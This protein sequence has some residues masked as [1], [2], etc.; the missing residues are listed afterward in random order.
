MS[1]RLS[2]LCLA[3]LAASGGV[4]HA[5]T[6]LLIHL[7]RP[8]QQIV[9]MGADMERSAAALQTAKNKDEIIRW[10]FDGTEGVDY[11]RVSFNKH[12]EPERDNKKMEIYD[13]QIASMKQ[14]K[15]VRPGIRFWATPKTDFDGYGNENNLPDWIYRGGGYNGGK[16]DPDQLETGLYAKFLLDYLELMHRNGV[17]IFCLSPSKEWSQV[18]SPEKTSQV[19]RYLKNA[20]RAH[21]VPMPIIVGPASWSVTGGIRDLK[22]IQ[23][24]GDG[25]LYA[26]FCTHKYNNSGSEENVRKFV[27]LAASMGKRAFNDEAGMGAAGRTSGVEP[28]FGRSIS[29]FFNRAGDYRAGLAGEIFF[30]NWSRG[31]NSETRSIYFKRGGVGKRMRAHWLFLEFAATTMNGWYVPSL[32]GTPQENL[33]TMVFWKGEQLTLW[34][35]NQNETQPETIDIRLSGGRLSDAKAEIVTWSKDSQNIRG[36]RVEAKAA[37]ATQ[38]IFESKPSSINVI[39]L[40]LT[41]KSR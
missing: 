6:R 8:Q 22:Q 20:C 39:R 41:R 33:E 12:Q 37:S 29:S 36:D 16:Y 31:I 13:K 7:D 24:L 25:S 35:M 30:E 5:Q 9:V 34:L 40:H 15:A 14:I 32:F 10:L 19:I 28:D 26:G 18:I 38:L 27:Q 2:L 23:K 17:S 3:L 21:Q 4:S 11:L 1:I